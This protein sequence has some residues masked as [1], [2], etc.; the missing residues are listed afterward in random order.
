MIS[1]LDRTPAL[2]VVDLQ[3]GIV[4][5]PTVHPAS[6]GVLRVRALLKQRDVAS[7]HTHA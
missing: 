6:D 7:A 2:V 3:R 4:S 5:V 1:T